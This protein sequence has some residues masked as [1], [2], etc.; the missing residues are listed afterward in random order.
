MA[1][2]YEIERT[3]NENNGV[4]DSK[5]YLDICRNSPQIT[6]VKYNDFDKFFQIWTND[7]EGEFRFQVVLKK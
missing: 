6:R 4:L 3:I 2:T 7:R 5:T 1:Y